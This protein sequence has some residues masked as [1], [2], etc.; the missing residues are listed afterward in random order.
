M[1]P[2]VAKLQETQ[3]VIDQASV[4]RLWKESHLLVLVCDT[5]GMLR[6]KCRLGRCES[7]RVQLGKDTRLWGLHTAVISVTR[8]SYD[9]LLNPVGKGLACSTQNSSFE[10]HLCCCNYQ[11][12]SLLN[13][14][15]VFHN[16]T[17]CNLPVFS[18]ME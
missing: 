18:L 13:Y 5:S 16:R 1:S 10:R 3:L 12:F 9:L 6:V 8:D 11:L 7:I 14:R 4:V 17:L 2:W 15:V